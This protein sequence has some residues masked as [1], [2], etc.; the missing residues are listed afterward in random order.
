MVSRYGR[1]GE[2]GIMEDQMR[3][4]KGKWAIRVGGE[5]AVIDATAPPKDHRSEEPRWI[6]KEGVR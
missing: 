6:E 4:G 3:A 1:D 2:F 5:A